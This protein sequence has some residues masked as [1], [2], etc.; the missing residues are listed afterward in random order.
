MTPGLGPKIDRAG[1]Q[2]IMHGFI[3]RGMIL[4]SNNSI[5]PRLCS[6]DYQKIG[7]GGTYVTRDVLGSDPIR[8]GALL[9]LRWSGNP[10]LIAL[11]AGFSLFYTLGNH[12]CQP[13][14]PFL[15]KASL[16][17]G[18]LS[19]R[20]CTVWRYGLAIVRACLVSS[21][22]LANQA[23]SELPRGSIP[24]RVLTS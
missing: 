9:P 12:S 7:V 18:L 16:V 14:P 23:N 20:S 17:R 1:Y 3:S 8:T 13:G 24:P 10:G 11:P 19:G 6:V 22:W 15:L 2:S 5:R 4:D 21:L